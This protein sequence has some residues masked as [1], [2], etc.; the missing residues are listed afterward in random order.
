MKGIRETGKAGQKSGGQGVAVTMMDLDD[1]AI[2]S[3]MID[4]YM[5]AATTLSEERLLAEYFSKHL[6]KDGEKAIATLLKITALPELPE[7]EAVSEK[8]GRTVISPLGA[9]K[10]RSLKRHAIWK[11]AAAVTACAAILV[12]GI[13]LWR[14]AGPENSI[15]PVEIAESLSTMANLNIGGIESMTAQPVGDAV[16]ITAKLKDGSTAAYLLTRGTEDGEL[17][18]L[19]M[20]E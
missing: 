3:K 19:A 16:V 9:G 15:T 2:R 10:A 1:S 14:P 6:A 20:A 13:I 5:E 8:Y 4:K 12:L 17:K 18:M 7:E 11:W